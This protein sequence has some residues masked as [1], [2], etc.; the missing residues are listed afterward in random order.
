M[1][2]G[3]IKLWRSLKNNPV[4]ENPEYLSV[5]IYILL[6]V[7]YQDN[8]FIFNDEKI[9]IKSGSFITSRAK[10]AKSIDVQ[11]SKVERILKYL[12]SEQQI[13]QQTFNKFRIITI[14]NW[15]KYQQT[16]QENEQPVNNK[17]TTSEQQVNT[18]KKDKKEKKV[19]K[20]IDIIPKIQFLDAVFL[21]QSEYDKLSAKYTKEKTDHAIEI[22]NNGIMSKGYK[23]K[24]HYHTII[25]WPMKEAQG[26]G[27]P[28]NTQIGTGS[29]APKAGRA[30]SDGEPYPIDFES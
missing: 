30:K 4:M 7:N 18:I 24:S 28:G 8:E 11:E 20:E 3:Y 17:R 5:W 1:E 10:I 19:K 21:L 14:V 9:L 16:E 6:S 27:R 22:L 26:N 2:G 13:E 15:N 25:G 12:K 29:V 23:Y